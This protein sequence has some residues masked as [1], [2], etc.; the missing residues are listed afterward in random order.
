MS[1]ENKAVIAV[2]VCTIFA[3]SLL[4]TVACAQTTIPKP[5]VPEFS[6][7]PVG[8]SFDIPPTYTFNSSTGLFDT[9][10]GYHIQYS[11]V[12]I[13]IKN[14]QFLNQSDSDHFYYNIR[15]KPHNYPD[16]YWL[17]LFSA[18]AN[19]Y[20]IQNLSNYT[21][22][23]VAVEGAQALGPIIRTGATTDIQV[24]AMI[25][26][27]G[28]NNTMI[29]YPYPYVLFGETSGWS[30]TQTVTLP[31]K[32]AFKASLSP[33]PTLNVSLSESASALYYGNRINF[34]VSADGGTKPYTFAWY[35]DNQLV[36]TSGSQYFSVDSQAVGS[37]H[38]YVQ[39]TD[40]DNN[41]ATTL[42]VEFNVLPVSNTSPS[43]GLS[44]SSS[45]TQQPT[46][47]PSQVP[48]NTQGN[49]TSVVII[50]GIVAVAIALGLLVYL[51]KNR[52][53]EQ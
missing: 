12:K 46:I 34:T 29:P 48:N 2:L 7:V 17:E 39:V 42:T 49:F 16:N 45:Q 43:L 27:I 8:P 38:V 5:S 18:G 13:T 33:T 11:T 1:V 53:R 20:P 23:P 22:I 19:G 30:N 14:Q 9:N 24:E 41:S 47:E 52:G 25:G 31:P 6:I 35:I 3:S 4:V 37:H 28:R 26:H 21:T 36:V 51:A 44:P 32:T 40:S 10:D 50:F 15:I